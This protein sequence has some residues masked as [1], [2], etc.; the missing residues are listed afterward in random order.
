MTLLSPPKGRYW[1]GHLLLQFEHLFFQNKK[2]LAHL[3][4][5]TEK[6]MDLFDKVADGILLW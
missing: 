4:P 6:G 1:T 5:L 3:L 2:S